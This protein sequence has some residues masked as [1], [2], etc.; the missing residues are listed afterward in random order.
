MRAC[1]CPRGVSAQFVCL[2]WVRCI[3]SCACAHAGPRMCKCMSARSLHACAHLF[4]AL[5]GTSTALHW[6]IFFV[7]V[8][9]SLLFCTILRC[10]CYSAR[11]PAHAPVSACCATLTAHSIYDSMFK[12]RILECVQWGRSFSQCLDLCRRT[13]TCKYFTFVANNAPGPV[14]RFFSNGSK[15][16][17]RKSCSD[18]LLFHT[19]PNGAPYACRNCTPRTH[20]LY[21][22]KSHIGVTKV[23]LRF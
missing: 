20:A 8:L 23:P 17:S 14:K 10:F 18:C 19:C 6:C 9:Y 22:P 21:T 7:L 11:V 15:C 12:R 1:M 13:Q 5:F 3:R 2:S 16:R 4:A